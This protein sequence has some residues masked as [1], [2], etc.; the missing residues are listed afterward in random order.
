MD[1]SGDEYTI[2]IAIR[3]KQNNYQNF[4]AN[5]WTMHELENFSN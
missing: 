2:R 3:T 1:F 5:Y 4:Y